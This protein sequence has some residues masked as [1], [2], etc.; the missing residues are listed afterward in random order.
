MDKKIYDLGKPYSTDVYHYTKLSNLFSIITKDGIIFHAG[1]FD[2][3]NDP[4]DSV[5]ITNMENERRCQSFEYDTFGEFGTGE[6]MPFLISFSFVAPFLCVLFLSSFLS[7]L[8][9]SASFSLSLCSL[10]SSVL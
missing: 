6:V 8:S 4:N 10:L 1:R 9:P 5:L 3:M 7:F 2:T